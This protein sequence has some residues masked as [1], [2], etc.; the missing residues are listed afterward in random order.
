MEMTRL[1]QMM[2]SPEEF[3]V[4]TVIAS[5]VSEPEN[6]SSLEEQQ[7]TALKAFLNRKDFFALLP[8]GFGNRLI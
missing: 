5:A 4:A 8:V 3:S 2:P 6:I 7:R 1:E